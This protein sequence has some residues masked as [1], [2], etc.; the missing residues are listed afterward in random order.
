MLGSPSNTI[1]PSF[2]TSSVISAFVNVKCPVFSNDFVFFT[3]VLFNV[4]FASLS[5]F[6]VVLPLKSIA[7]LSLSVPSNVK[8]P[9]NVISP[10]LS[11]V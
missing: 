2:V 5:V 6:K 1:S 8:S 7:F 3:V 4:T 9:F 11:Y 10:L